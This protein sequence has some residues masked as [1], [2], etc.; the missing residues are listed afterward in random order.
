VNKQ[1]ML[2]RGLVSTLPQDQQDA[3]QACKKDI[4]TV[5]S[6]YDEGL[7]MLA[8]ALIGSEAID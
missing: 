2:I 1:N 6:G 8:V 4:E 5:M 3:I 7:W